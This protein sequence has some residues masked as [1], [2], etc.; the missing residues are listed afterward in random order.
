M[1][2]VFSTIDWSKFKITAPSERI[3]LCFSVSDKT[4]DDV[5]AD[6]KSLLDVYTAIRDG[7]ET[8]FVAW[9]DL[10][11]HGVV[12]PD[13]NRRYTFP[14]ERISYEGEEDADGWAESY[15]GGV[16]YGLTRTG[17][18]SAF[19]TCREF[20]EFMRDGKHTFNEFVHNQLDTMREA[21]KGVK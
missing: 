19:S 1:D 14:K 16:I 10:K 5:I 2:F 12:L 21:T 8:E 15:D 18:K 20:G 7:R 9:G 13:K 11:D 6:L 3:D 17:N 4:L